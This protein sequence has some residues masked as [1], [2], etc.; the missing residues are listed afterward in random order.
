MRMMPGE[1][2]LRDAADMIEHGVD[3]HA[4]ARHRAGVGEGLHAVDELHDAV[5]LVA[6][7]LRQRPIVVADRELR[8][9]AP[10]R[11]CPRAGS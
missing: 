1:A 2:R 11:G 7:E 5:G 9:I 10:R 4:F 6:D 8:A 3:V